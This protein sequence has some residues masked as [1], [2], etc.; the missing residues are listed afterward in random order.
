VHVFDV[1]SGEFV[2]A[3]SATHSGTGPYADSDDTMAQALF[4]EIDDSYRPQQAAAGGT[5]Q[6]H[7]P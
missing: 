6:E 1:K 7:K 2:P 5:R 4:N 3:S